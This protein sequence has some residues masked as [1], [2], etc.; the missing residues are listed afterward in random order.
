MGDTLGE[1]SANGTPY[2]AGQMDR[3]CVMQPAS[4]G[5]SRPKTL[6]LSCPEIRRHLALQSVRRYSR[7]EIRWHPQV[8]R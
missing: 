7:L 4:L 2:V 6:P 3:F 1:T 5:T 8:A